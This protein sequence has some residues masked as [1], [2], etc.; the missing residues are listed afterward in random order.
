M[1]DS[2]VIQEVASLLAFE[3]L[4]I[5]VNRYQVCK[6]DILK[7]LNTCTNLFSTHSSTFFIQLAPCSQKKGQTEKHYFNTLRF[8]YLTAPGIVIFPL[9]CT[10]SSSFI[11]LD[12]K[13]TSFLKLIVG[14]HLLQLN[15][16]Y[17]ST[18][19]RLIMFR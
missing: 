14:R 13:F 15:S 16:Q 3:S 10:F 11:F 5:Q 19:V 8:R 18:D 4:Q 6:S 2:K 7:V 12:L 1:G 17:C 9:G